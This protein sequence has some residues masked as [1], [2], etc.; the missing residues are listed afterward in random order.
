MFILAI[1]ILG[2]MLS[3]I[4]FVRMWTIK[5]YIEITNQFGKDYPPSTTKFTPWKYGDEPHREY[6]E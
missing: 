1:I 5:N 6:T 4:G 2:I 3:L